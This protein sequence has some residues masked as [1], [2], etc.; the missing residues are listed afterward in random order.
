M[1]TIYHSFIDLLLILFPQLTEGR[2]T[3]A[4]A[5]KVGMLPIWDKWGERHAVTVLQLDEC[6]V[7]QVK[8]EDT[9][10]YVAMQLGVGEAKRCRVKISAMG[11]YKR[12]DVKP[13]RKLMEFRVSPDSIVPEGI[14]RIISH[15]T[16]HTTILTFQL[17]FMND[18]SCFVG[19]RIRALHFVPGQFVDVC[20]ISKGKGFQGVMKRWNFSGGRAS[21]GNSLAHRI[22][23]NYPS[24]RCCSF[25]VVVVVP[26][27]FQVR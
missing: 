14:I 7:V 2:R 19:T 27:I 23:G 26:S 13:K 20:G 5:M 25:L 24:I 1:H 9:D 16:S 12:A 8:R 22:P 17:S 11:H 10:G 3:G 15:L 21:H 4:L 18:S 6:D